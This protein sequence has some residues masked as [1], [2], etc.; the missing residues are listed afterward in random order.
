ME[1]NKEKLNINLKAIAKYCFRVFVFLVLNGNF[2]SF[3][4]IDKTYNLLIKFFYFSSG[5]NPDFGDGICILFLLS[6]LF[7]YLTAKLCGIFTEIKN[8]KF[9]HALFIM[10]VL[11]ILFEFSQSITIQLFPTIKFGIGNIG[12]PCLYVVLINFLIY[13]FLTF[14]TKNTPFEKIGYFFS[15]DFWKKFFYIF[16]ER[17]LTID[18]KAIY[19]NS[20]K[21]LKEKLNKK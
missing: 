6:Y 7:N 20:F 10:V 8:F 15:F 18:Y 13:T 19:Q 17:I 5:N 12:L 21:S 1:I 9:Y 2:I 14:I 4:I 16:I 3:Y 11:E